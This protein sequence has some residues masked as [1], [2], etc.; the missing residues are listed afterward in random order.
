[1]EI[2]RAYKVQKKEKEYEKE[3]EKD[4]DEE[5]R[6]PISPCLVIGAA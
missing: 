4:L 6:K 3:K 2:V 1:M 5:E